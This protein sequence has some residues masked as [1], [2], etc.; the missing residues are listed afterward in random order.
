MSS[1]ISNARPPDPDVD[2]RSLGASNPVEGGVSART[3]LLSFAG[4]LALLVIALCAAVTATDPSRYFFGSPVPQI[5]PNTPRVKVELFR[6][7]SMGGKVTGLLLG[8]SRCALLRPEQADRITGLRFFNASVYDASTDH[9]LAIYRLFRKIQAAPPKMLIV[10]LDTSLLSSGAKI[11]EDLPANYALIS[12]LD[13]GITLPWHFAKLYARYLRAQTFIDLWT[14][15]KNWRSPK[16]PLEV[17]SPDGHIEGRNAPDPAKHHPQDALNNMEPI[18]ANYRAFTAVSQARVERLRALLR[19]ASADNA[20]ILLWLTPVH[21]ALRAAIAEI[22]GVP[23]K[24]RQARQMILDMAAEFHARIVDLSA[25]DSFGGQPSTWLD[26]VHVSAIDAQREMN[27]L[28][29]SPQNWR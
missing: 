27:R 8:S 2:N 24:D 7:Y 13:G 11:S 17:F 5:W 16:P 4:T 12:Q 1:S 3:F 23:V 26:A 28:L 15:V 29:A 25:P 20:R 9:Y 10:G 18:L 19:E 21:P 22:P 14:S 6:R